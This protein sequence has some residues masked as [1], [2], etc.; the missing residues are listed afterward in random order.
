MLLQ[1]L[2]V[3]GPDYHHVKAIVKLTTYRRIE[4]NIQIFGALRMKRF[5][6]QNSILSDKWNIRLYGLFQHPRKKDKG[7]WSWYLAFP[8]YYGM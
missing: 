7:K 1:P 3:L 5:I 2:N 4:K 8:K 6:L